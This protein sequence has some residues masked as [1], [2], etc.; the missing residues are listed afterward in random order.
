MYQAHRDT[1]RNLVR[2]QF[3]QRHETTPG[4]DVHIL[5]I[6]GDDPDKLPGLWQAHLD[7]FFIDFAV[8]Q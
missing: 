1:L 2:Q 7:H 4:F 8:E 3:E 6:G 5:D